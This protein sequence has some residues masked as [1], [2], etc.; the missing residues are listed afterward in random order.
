MDLTMDEVRK[1]QERKELIVCDWDGVVQSIE[2][3]WMK[4]VQ[5][6]KDVFKGYF[7]ETFYPDTYVPRDGK[8]YAEFITSR[9][10]YYLNE[11]MRI[12]GVDK[13]DKLE[14]LF[15]DLYEQYEFFYEDCMYCPMASG[16]ALLVRQDFCKVIF[17]SHV[18]STFENTHDERKLKAFEKFRDD[19]D[20]GD[21]VS[22]VMI[23]SDV[24]KST[25]INE[26]VSHYTSFV[27]DRFDIIMDVIQNTDSKTK[28][29]LMPMYGYSVKAY[30]TYDNAQEIIDSKRV[31]FQ[32]Y[33]KI[34]DGIVVKEKEEENSND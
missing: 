3:I 12:P 30:N 18:P 4:L 6:N 10:E 26:N 21:K 19:N 33:A 24:K 23:P 17:L 8:N 1:I 2:L 15:M 32:Y 34:H 11:W 13:N 14:K 25:W 5:R 20:L 27:D 22:L 31:T 9:T 28:T 16:L 29:M 7:D